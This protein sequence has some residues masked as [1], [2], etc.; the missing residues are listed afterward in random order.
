MKKIGYNLL[1]ISLILIISG[2]FST[3]LVGLKKDRDEVLARM[4]D[5]SAEYE[6]FSTNVSL[7]GDYR[8]DLHQ[9]IFENLFLETMFSSDS[10]VKEELKKYETMVDEIELNVNV[11]NDLCQNVYYPKSDVNSMCKNYKTMYEQ[12]VNY[13]VVDIKDYNEN[14]EKYDQYQKA[15]NL[16]K[17]VKKYE[18]T[19]SYID[20]DGDKKYAGKEE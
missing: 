16:G 13:F 2:A 8:E 1:A 20:Y 12:V 7:Y 9:S 6:K 17:V 19:K 11:L 14:V 4:G 18:T 3:Y 5:V 10:L 15:N